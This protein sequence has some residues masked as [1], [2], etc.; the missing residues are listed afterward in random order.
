[1][2]YE[3]MSDFE[4]KC[5]VANKK[6]YRNMTD[7]Q[8]NH[9]VSDVLRIPHGDDWCNS[10]ADSGPIIQENEISIVFVRIN[11]HEFTWAAS[12]WGSKWK[13]VGCKNKNPLRAAMIVFLMMQENK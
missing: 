7:D 10:W 1:M 6:I 11:R 12:L 9:A 8:I 3:E 2:N 5:D 13:D 4:I